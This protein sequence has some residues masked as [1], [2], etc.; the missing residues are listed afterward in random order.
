[1]KLYEVER[2]SNIKLDDGEG[3]VLILKFHHVDGMYGYCTD[4][5]GNVI[6]LAAWSDVEVQK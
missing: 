1:M 4:Q 2:G 6:H 5:N 3:N